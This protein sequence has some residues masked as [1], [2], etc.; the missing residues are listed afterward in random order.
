MNI[1]CNYQFSSISCPNGN[2]TNPYT[3]H[4]HFWS[5]QGT[6]AK[7]TVYI[8]VDVEGIAIR[9]SVTLD[10]EIRYIFLL[11]TSDFSDFQYQLTFCTVHKIMERCCFEMSI[12]DLSGMQVL[13]TLLA[14]SRSQCEPVR[15]VLAE[16]RK[17][18]NGLI[19]C[20]EDLGDSDESEDD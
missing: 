16:L 18:C 12:N 5:A 8:D 11:D 14:L 13:H 15:G 17:H 4:I 6:V 9:C 20:N 19:P 1:T 2:S 7:Y 3:C 10:D